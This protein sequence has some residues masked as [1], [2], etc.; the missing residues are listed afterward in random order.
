MMMMMVRTET[1]L[2]PAQLE[3]NQ[4]GHA[5][6]GPT[7]EISTKRRFF[8]F[9]EYFSAQK[10]HGENSRNIKQAFAELTVQQRKEHP[11]EI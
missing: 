11:F 6:D 1:T 10:I 4:E 7:Y 2:S 8:L 5:K 3:S 9:E